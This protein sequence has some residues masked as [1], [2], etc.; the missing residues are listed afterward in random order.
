MA[1][2]K[3]Q[4][5]AAAAVE[6]NKQASKLDGLGLD[7]YQSVNLESFFWRAKFATSPLVGQA[8]AIEEDIPTRFKTQDNPEG[9][10]TCI[11]AKLEKPATWLEKAGGETITA[12]A[13]A[14]VRI[15]S[16]NSQLKAVEREVRQ[17]LKQGKAMGLALAFT[18][19]TV[20]P[21]GER[22]DF[23][24][25][26]QPAERWVDLKQVAP[27]MVGFGANFDVEVL[28]PATPIKQLAAA[29]NGAAQA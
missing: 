11:I 15:P 23:E 19:T 29:P 5:T 13:G 24:Y 17:A 12:P 14:Y 22:N 8:I 10:M 9:F 26:R 20:T 6:T 1:D 25:R 28:P 2:P 4:G 3:K 27:E 7:D 21:K 18:G 16:N